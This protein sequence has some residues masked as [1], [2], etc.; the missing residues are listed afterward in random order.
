MFLDSFDAEQCYTRKFLL[1]K[2]GYIH[3]NPVSKR[4]QLVD[5]FTDYENSSAGFYEK[6]IMRYDKILHVSEIW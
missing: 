5:D 3:K 2:L 4:W 6:G 1:Q